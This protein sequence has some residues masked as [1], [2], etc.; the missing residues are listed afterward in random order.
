MITSST[1]GYR[2]WLHRFACL[3]AAGTFLLIV[4]GASV[5]SNRAGLSVPDWPT[6]YG[7]PLLQFPFSKMVGGIFYE[8]GHRLIASA[9]GLLT[10]ILAVWLLRAE[11]RCGVRYLGLAALGAVLLQGILGGLTVKLF[12]PPSVSVAHAALAEAFFCITIALAM[13]TSRR[14]FV[15]LPG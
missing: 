4:A 5:T 15:A 12:L 11:Q 3:L 8:H 2:P 9:V 1:S 13:L 6:S 7:Y 14:W 10:L